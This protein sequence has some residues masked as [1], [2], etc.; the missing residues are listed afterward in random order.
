MAKR[1]TKLA[2]VGSGVVTYHWKKGRWVAGAKDPISIWGTAEKALAARKRFF[3]SLGD[4]V[5]IDK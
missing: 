5:E 2:I 3:E 4:S 1:R